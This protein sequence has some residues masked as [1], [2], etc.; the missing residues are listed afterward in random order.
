MKLKPT[1]AAVLSVVG[2]CT[3]APSAHADPAI[4]SVEFIPM[5]APDTADKKADIYTGAKM[6]VTYT[7]RQIRRPT[8]SNITS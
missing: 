6:K 4:K 1:A 3:L 5:A 7:E 8:I 2:V